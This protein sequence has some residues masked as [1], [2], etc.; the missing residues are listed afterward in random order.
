MGTCLVLLSCYSLSAVLATKGLLWAPSCY[1]FRILLLWTQK[2]LVWE[3]ACGS[4]PLYGMCAYWICPCSYGIYYCVTVT[5]PMVEQV[6][7]PA[8]FQA[9]SFDHPELRQLAQALPAI[10]VHDRAAKTVASYLRAYKSWK[11]W[12][13]RHDAACLPADCVVFTLYVVS[14]IQQT[15]SVSSVNSA[16]YGV[17]WVHRKSGYQEP[18]EYPV[19]KQVVDAARRILARPAE[20]KEPLSSVLVRKVISRLEKGNLGDLQLA[21]LFSLGFF[22]F[23]RWDDLRHLSVDSFYFADSHVA[24]FLEKR[25]NDQFREGS[26]VFVARCNTPPCPVEITEKFLSIANHSKGSPLF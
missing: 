4:T 9:D 19:V 26:W 2:I 13:S 21:A 25:K 5:Q 17:S 12:A 1:G 14:L 10:L 6:I 15:R 22:G 18:S 11:S 20:R 7:F 23:L 3:Y 24:I 16:V 8:E